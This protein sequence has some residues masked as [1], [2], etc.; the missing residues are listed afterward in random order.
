MQ[1]ACSLHAGCIQ[2]ACIRS[3][4]RAGCHS[5]PS[6]RDMLLRIKHIEQRNICES[7]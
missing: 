6:A 4:N 5:C 1:P 3:L 2:A 7:V